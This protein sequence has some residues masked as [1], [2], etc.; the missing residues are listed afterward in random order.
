QAWKQILQRSPEDTELTAAL[1]YLHRQQLLFTQQAESTARSEHDESLDQKQLAQALSFHLRADQAVADDQ[2][3]VS[4]VKDLSGKDRHLSQSNPAAQPILI[5]QAAAFNHQPVLAL[6][7][8]GQFLAI[9]GPLLNQQ[10][11][12]IVCVAAD[13]GP[14]GHRE[15]I[16][17]WNRSRN[18]GSSVFLGLTADNTVRFSDVFPSAGQVIDREKPFILT[19]VNSSHEATVR[20]NGATLNAAGSPL[21]ERRLDTPWVVGQQGDIN[22]EFWKGS[23]AEIRVYGRAL[24]EQELNHVETELSQR[25]GIPLRVPAAEPVLDPDTLALASL[26]HVLLNTNEFVYVD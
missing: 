5:A 13:N 19:A 8:A 4:A 12:T 17:N 22:G 15:L 20:Q 21:A 7:G 2:G 6:D 24:S 3:R 18:V 23:I 10:Q 25:Y 26:C 14:A 1:A 16:S 9:H 11:M